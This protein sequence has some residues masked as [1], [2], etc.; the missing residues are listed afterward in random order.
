MS[1]VEI[2]HHISVNQHVIC[3]DEVEACSVSNHHQCYKAF[4]GNS[5]EEEQQ[6]VD[7]VVEGEHDDYHADGNQ[8][9]VE[10]ALYVVSHILEEREVECNKSIYAEQCRYISGA[11][12]AGH[13]FLYRFNDTHLRFLNIRYIA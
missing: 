9:T 5:S 6:I 8:Y 12:I 3:F 7:E 2:T 11:G 4:A 10:V 13:T 1:V